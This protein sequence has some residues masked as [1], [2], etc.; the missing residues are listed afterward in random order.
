MIKEISVS[1][2]RFYGGRE[3]DYL[4]GQKLADDCKKNMAIIQW[5]PKNSK[6]DFLI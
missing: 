4:I 2:E 1:Y 6:L 3:F 5:K